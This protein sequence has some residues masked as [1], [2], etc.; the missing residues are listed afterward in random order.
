MSQEEIAVVGLGTMGSG[1]AARLLD[2]GYKV[3][4]YN[5]TEAAAACFVERGAR[6]AARPRD[7]AVPGGIAITMVA[8][9]EALEAVTLGDEG[10]VHLV[11]GGLGAGAVA[12]DAGGEGAGDRRLLG[13]VEA[14]A[15]GCERLQRRAHHA[16]ARHQL[17]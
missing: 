3:G 6:L 8:N 14:A 17:G 7:V 1:L 15:F 9:D 13:D 4:V 5:R 12:Q 11:G 16:G 2:L 10:L